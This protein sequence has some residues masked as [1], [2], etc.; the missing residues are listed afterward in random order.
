MATAYVSQST[1]QLAVFVLPLIYEDIGRESLAMLD[2]TAIESLHYCTYI[3][4]VSRGIKTCNCCFG[5]VV[6]LM[7][8][9]LQGD[10]EARQIL[11]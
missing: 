11:H 2:R 3:G 6:G 1:S 9:L 7:P 5:V 8:L 4:S 10:K